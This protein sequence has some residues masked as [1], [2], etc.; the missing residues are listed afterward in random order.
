MLEKVSNENGRKQISFILIVFLTLLLKF[1][2][3][4]KK[5]LS[6]ILK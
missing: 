2:Q 5:K 1:T 4:K 6:E 3:K